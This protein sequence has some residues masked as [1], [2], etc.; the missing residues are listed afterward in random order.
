MAI[1]ILYRIIWRNIF[2]FMKIESIFCCEG[3]CL[4]VVFVGRGC[5]SKYE[6]IFVSRLNVEM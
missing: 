6:L 2:Y 1:K 5:I 4:C 3:V